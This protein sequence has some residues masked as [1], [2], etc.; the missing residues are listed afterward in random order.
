MIF[1]LSKSA[2]KLLCLLISLG[3]SNVYIKV[4]RKFQKQKAYTWMCAYTN[5]WLHCQGH[6]RLH[7]NGTIVEFYI[8][9]P[10]YQKFISFV[11]RCQKLISL[12]RE[13][14]LHFYISNTCL[15]WIQIHAQNINHLSNSLTIYD[16]ERFNCLFSVHKENRIMILPHNWCLYIAINRTHLT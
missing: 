6:T 16:I 13:S 11:F 7:Y 5:H 3:L 15:W 14:I 2:D 1:I 4:Q 8:I 9:W 10:K 12:Q